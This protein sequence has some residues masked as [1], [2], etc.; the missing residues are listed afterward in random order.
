MGP[1]IDSGGWAFY[2]FALGW[3]RG[4]KATA[5]VLPLCPRLVGR[6]GH[7][8]ALEKSMAGVGRSTVLPSVGC[9]EKRSR[10][11]LGKVDG[12]GGAFY[13]FSLNW[14]PGQLWGSGTSKC[15]TVVNFGGCGASK[16]ETIINVGVGGY[17][18]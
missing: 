1:S 5:G 3:L 12:G 9:R 7:S 15:E 16:Y 14:I 18:V 17:T 13:L 10:R 8:R 4:G 2:L 6:Q 11:G